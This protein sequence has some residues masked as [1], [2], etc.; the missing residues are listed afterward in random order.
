MN[1]VIF[2]LPLLVYLVFML[3]PAVLVATTFHDDFSTLVFFIILVS[4]LFYLFG[5]FVFYSLSSRRSNIVITSFF[6]C[7]MCFLFFV[8]VVTYL[9]MFYDYG[10]APVLKY[11]T[12]GGAPNVLRADFY[13]NKEGVLNFFV[14]LRSVLMKGFVPFFAIYSYVYFRRVYFYFFAIIYVLL[15]LVTF[16]K[17]VLIWFFLPLLV[18]FIYIKQYKKLFGVVFL[19]ILSVV[20]LSELQ[21]KD[22]KGSTEGLGFREDGW[23]YSSLHD[24]NKYQF[25]FTDVDSIQVLPF[26]IDRMFWIPYVTVYDTLLYWQKNYDE[27]LFFSTNRHLSKMF[28]YEFANIEREVFVFQYGGNENTTGNAN[29][30]YFSEA[31]LMFGFTGVVFFSLF[32]GVM[33]GVVLGSKNIVF[34][35]VYPLYVFSVISSASLISMLFSGGLL[36]FLIIFIFYSRR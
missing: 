18:Y 26:L 10:G 29:S 12:S 19:S 11:F 22:N 7:L 1:I 13:K 14:Y 30:A 32:F 5:Y 23:K 28:D 24:N 15:S 36:V 4:F 34:K 9:F 27:Y 6:K 16:E 33:S 3:A 17:G 35:S 20:F 31:Y 21:H 8:F 2:V 25:Y